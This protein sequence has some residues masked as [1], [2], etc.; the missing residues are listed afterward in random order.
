MKENLFR[1]KILEIL[2]KHYVKTE[3]DD[4]FILGLPFELLYKKTN[5]DKY[6]F[7]EITSVLYDEKEIEYHDANGVIGIFSTEKGLASF[8]S[9]KYYKLFWNNI[10]DNLKSIIQ[11]IIPVLSLVITIMV[12]NKDDLKTTKEIQKMKNEIKSLRRDILLKSKANS[13][14]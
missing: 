14:F 2:S 3:V 4:G 7:R 9:K 1:H 13:K 12:I 8:S 5:L 10:F 6:R 11:I